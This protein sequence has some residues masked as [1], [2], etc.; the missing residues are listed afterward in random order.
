M[1]KTCSYVLPR[2]SESKSRLNGL[3]CHA[4]SL[5]S[6]RFRRPQDC[7]ALPTAAPGRL[8]S[9]R[10]R[11]P[12]DC[13]APPITAPDISVT[14]GSPFRGLSRGS[15][16]RAWH[17]RSSKGRRPEDLCAIPTNRPSVSGH[18]SVTEPKIAARFQAL[19]LKS[20]SAAG[21]PPGRLRR[22]SNHCTWRLRLL[23]V[24]CLK[25][26]GVVQIAAPGVSSCRRVAIRKT[27][28][29]FQPPRLVSPVATRSSS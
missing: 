21:S 14:A 11:R 29:R 13:D 22:G 24:D 23:R 10:G 5:Q 8:Q 1:S 20:P 15:N 6:P 3:C 7:D 4:R 17:L 19:H 2:P 25:D 28:A 26:R 9:P 16:C 27:A 18:R 12:E